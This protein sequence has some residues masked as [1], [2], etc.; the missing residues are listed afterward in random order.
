MRKLLFIVLSVF[1]STQCIHAQNEK[2]RIYIQV[3]QSERENIPQE[4]AQ[5]LG[6]KLNQLITANGIAS[7]D[8]SCR[9]VLTSKASIISKDIIGG[10]PA[11]VSMK[12]DFTFMVG[13]AEENKIFESK[14]ISSVGVGTNENKAMIMALKNIKP[15]SPELSA[16]IKNAK[17][18]ILSYYSQRCGEIK[19]EAQQL[20]ANRDY[21]G[22][23]YQLMRIPE[24]CE[25]SDECQALAIGYYEQRTE[26]KAAQALNEA[27]AVWAS[28]PNAD[29][30][31]RVAD[32]LSSIPSETKVQQG[33][34]DLTAE[35]N[36]KVKADER[37]E[38]NFKM[39]QY[40][41]RIAA[42]RREQQM[43]AEQNRA[44]NE[45]RLRSIEASRQVGLEYARHQ[46]K[47][48]VYNRNVILW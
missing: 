48:V 25:C 20:A 37:R 21:D 6:N 38:W 40:N 41:D 13:D 33:I 7:D 24:I 34:E 16:F 15:L 17:E 19:I 3:L 14:T 30:A 8:P 1:A 35:I 10:A 28:S 31:S 23:I 5:Q 43:R 12:V 36:A 9:F 46:P 11:R 47:T 2:D 45:A 26:E 44:N 29:G 32:I 18:K 27:K 4:A 42:E 22:A 39:Q